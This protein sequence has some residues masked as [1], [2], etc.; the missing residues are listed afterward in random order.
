MKPRIGLTSVLVVAATVTYACSPARPAVN[1]SLPAPT[2]GVVTF[3]LSMPNSAADLAQAAAAVATPASGQYRRFVSETEAGAKYGA[4]DDQIDAVTDSIKTIGLQFAA[5]PSR[6]FGRVSGTAAQWQTALGAPL[7]V[8][9]A[10][11]S[12][13]FTGYTLP[14]QLPAA[15]EPSGT[16]MIVPQV[17]VYAPTAEGNRPPTRKRPDSEDANPSRSPR[18]AP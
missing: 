13:P 14:N 7:A 6:L 5:D 12:T 18:Q 1:V 2:T 16:T 17:Q 9:A 10:T 3:Y 11:A 8:Q 15:L 4:S